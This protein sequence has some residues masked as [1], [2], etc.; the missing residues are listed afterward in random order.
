MKVDEPV[1]V[2]IPEMVPSGD[3]VTPAGSAPFVTSQVTS[4]GRPAPSSVAEYEEPTAAAFNATVAIPQRRAQTSKVKSVSASL[5][6]AVQE[7]EPR[8]EGAGLGSYSLD[9]MGIEV[10]PSD[11]Q[12]RRKASRQDD[13]TVWQAACVR[14]DLVAVDM[15]TSA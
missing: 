15:P 13:E 9:D 1:A 8:A 12:P 14:A 4:D 2:G 10:D 6:V 5:V 7:L 3:N 11:R